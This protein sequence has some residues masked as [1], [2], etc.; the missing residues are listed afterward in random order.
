AQD[1]EGQVVLLSGEPGIGKSRILQE[2]RAHLAADAHI[3]LHFQCSP[4]HAN[5][6]FHPLIDQIERSAGFTREDTSDSKLDKLEAYVRRAGTRSPMALSLFAAMLSLPATRYPPLEF[7]PQ[8]QK[9]ETIRVLGEHV[10]ELSAQQPVLLLFEDAHWIDA[11][12]LEV[13][14]MAVP[15]VQRL[16]VL[17][18]ITFRPEFEP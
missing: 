4:Y 11:S 8:R 5:S 15:L 3:R 1:G 14:H 7:S 10:S 12:S 18:V 2:L 6:V 16:A 13:L 9:E 17:M